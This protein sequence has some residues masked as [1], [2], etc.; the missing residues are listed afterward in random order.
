MVHPLL[1][2]TKGKR[3]SNCCLSKDYMIQLQQYMCD[4]IY[5]ML[6]FTQYFKNTKNWIID[7]IFY[8]YPYFILIR[9]HFFVCF[10]H[11]VRERF[12]L[13]IKGQFVRPMYVMH[14]NGSESWAST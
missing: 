7:S 10:F 3:V 12:K 9:L 11:I 1:T 4:V 13:Y 14:T 5:K 6:G 2:T 8:N